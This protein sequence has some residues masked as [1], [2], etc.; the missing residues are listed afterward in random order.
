MNRQRAIE[1]IAGFEGRRL[2]VVGD[3]MLD[4][5]IWGAVRRI[6]PEAPV[7]VVEVE[8]ESQHL[9]GAGN[10][11]ANV[12]SLGAA[13]LPFGVVGDDASADLLAAEFRRAGV[14]TA[15]IARDASR[16]T[17][18][19]TRIVAHSQQVVRADR[20]R[21]HAVGGEA[22]EAIVGAFAALLDGAD[23]VVVSDYDKGLLAGGLLGR[24]L[25]AARDR[26]VPVCLDPKVRRFASYRPVTV[27]TPNH[28]EAEAA[29]GLPATTDT[30]LEACGRRIQ[31]M[32]G[33]PAVLITRGEAGMSLVDAAGDVAHVPTTAREVYDVTGAGD[34][35]IATLALALAAGAT[36]LEAAILANFAAGV[37]V[38][39]VGTATA[40]TTELTAAIT[41]GEG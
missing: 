35:V 9:G 12:V 31:E 40:T 25:E 38:G 41:R 23:A 26:G 4:R 36:T 20:E 11:V 8:R 22:E 19:K 7:P 32:L 5:F 16:P 3:L 21:R 6:S 34:T 13:A 10:V 29:T 17:T 33:G 37:V 39:K 28:H 27:I 24:V 15:G 14:D 2:A 18:T 1:L 30:E